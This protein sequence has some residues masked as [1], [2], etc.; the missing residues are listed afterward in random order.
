MNAHI[1]SFFVTA[2][3][4]TP[5]WWKRPKPLS[6][7]RRSINATANTI[8]NTTL[9]GPTGIISGMSVVRFAAF[10]VVLTV[11]VLRLDVQAWT[12]AAAWAAVPGRRV[13]TSTCSSSTRLYH[14][15]KN[16]PKHDV[17][18]DPFSS[19]PE[20][21]KLRAMA[22]MEHQQSVPKPGFPADVRSLVQYN[23]GFAV[24]STNSKS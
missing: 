9:P 20:D 24:M 12:A 8:L 17:G 7:T 5:T 3:S 18:G 15:P 16:V 6:L 4:V 13:L 14:A 23:H 10:L 21:Q 22:Y 2:S 11:T 1:L 19:L